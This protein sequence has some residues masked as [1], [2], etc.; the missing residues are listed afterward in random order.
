MQGETAGNGPADLLD[1]VIK[2]SKMDGEEPNLVWIRDQINLLFIG[3]SDTSSVSLW[4]AMILL[5]RHPDIQSKIKAEIKDVFAR[6]TESFDRI[7]QLKYLDGFIKEVL[8][9]YPP[10]ITA[11]RRLDDGEK[12]FRGFPV[13]D[14]KLSIIG[15]THLLAHRRDEYFPNADKLIPDRWL[16]GQADTEAFGSFSTGFRSCLGK[17]FAMIEM[18]TVLGLVLA[19]HTIVSVDPNAPL[20]VYGFV[21]QVATPVGKYDLRL[22]HDL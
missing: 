7:G 3:G 16:N 14:L 10:F 20:P 22:V 19:N 2:A 18:K 21:G 9:L 8:R 4:W 13:T 5:G 1:L 17:N 11:G 12:D 6:V 15:Y